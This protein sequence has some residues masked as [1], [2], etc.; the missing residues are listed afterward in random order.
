MLR[1]RLPVRMAVRTAGFE[2][3]FNNHLVL[4]LRFKES[5]NASALPR[6]L[7]PRFRASGFGT[8]E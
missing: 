2:T 7:R 3:N 8:D 5:G 4:T 1:S 6:V